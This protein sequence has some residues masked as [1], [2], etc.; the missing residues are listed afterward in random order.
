MY[1]VFGYG[2]AHG[3]YAQ[4]IEQSGVNN[5]GKRIVLLRVDR[6]M[7][8][9][10]YY[11]MMRLVHLQDPLLATIHQAI[12]SDLNL[13]DRVRSAVMDIENKTFWKALYNLIRSVYPAI[14]ALRYCDY[15]VLAMDNIYH[16]SNLTT[17]AIERS[18]EM[19]NN[20]F[21]NMYG[22]KL[23]GRPAAR[24]ERMALVIHSYVLV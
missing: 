2:A 11:A 24:L 1:N 19:L 12:F 3:I 4:F 9:Q 18:Y 16:L 15:N 5:N 10:Y 8:A 22:H 6:N 7:F 23:M 17:W 14:Q 21:R 20:D 13:N